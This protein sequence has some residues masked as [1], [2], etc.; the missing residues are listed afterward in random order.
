MDGRDW[1]EMTTISKGLSK[2]PSKMP[3]RGCFA[4][5]GPVKSFILLCIEAN[6]CRYHSCY[7]MGFQH[8]AL[9]RAHRIL[10]FKHSS[11]GQ[12]LDFSSF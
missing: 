6:K 11:F 2:I 3:I 7:A 12:R 8:N 9:G 1:P 4:K 10:I 5:V